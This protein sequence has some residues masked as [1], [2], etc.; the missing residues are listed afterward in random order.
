MPDIRKYLNLKTIK[1]QSHRIIPINKIKNANI[2]MGMAMSNSEIKYLV[3][4]Y[5]KL[6]N[7]T[8]VELMMFSQINS[9]HCRHKIFNSNFL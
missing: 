2:D 9:E 7:P 3:D 5:N 4:I 8:D 6:R 1:K